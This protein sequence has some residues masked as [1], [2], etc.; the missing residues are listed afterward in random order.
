MKNLNEQF[1][2]DQSMMCDGLLTRTIIIDDSLTCLC[3]N[4][5]FVKFFERVHLECNEGQNFFSLFPGFEGIRVNL[6]ETFENNDHSVKEQTGHFMVGKHNAFLKIVIEPKVYDGN[7]VCVFLSFISKA[8]QLRHAKLMQEL[9]ATNEKLAE[10]N[11]EL[12]A[13]NERLT[14]MQDELAIANEQLQKAMDAKHK[15]IKEMSHST[16]APLN[17]LLGYLGIAID[18]YAE[19]SSEEMLNRLT[20]AYDGVVATSQIISNSFD[21]ALLVSEE[22]KLVPM[23]IDLF[24]KVKSIKDLYR[25]IA[26]K[27]DIKIKKHES[28]WEVYVKS[29]EYVLDHVLQNLISNAIKFTPNG[30]EISI[31]AERAGNDTRIIVSDSGVGMDPEVV[32]ILLH[33]EETIQTRGT[34]QERGTGS[35]I[36]TCKELLTLQGGKLWIESEIGKGS[37]FYF[38]FPSA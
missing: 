4:S 31:S 16:N 28:L 11:E 38:T 29:D 30:G 27:K 17:S 13:A 37:K 22:F 36:K 2:K 20:V 15:I 24:T 6:K 7:V 3:M 19:I 10:T 8:K 5:K 25:I 26:A 32:D 21:R 33:T 1:V 12:V 35:G 34:N 14:R 9:K 18:D 23:K